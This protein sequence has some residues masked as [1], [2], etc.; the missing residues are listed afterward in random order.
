MPEIDETEGR[1]DDADLHALRA[2]VHEVDPIDPMWQIPPAGSWE[3]IA[4]E[5]GVAAAASDAAPDPVE[6]P[7][8]DAELDRGLDLE[9]RPHLPPV[10]GAPSTD[11]APGAGAVQ[12]NGVP[13]VLLLAVAVVVLFV[14]VAVVS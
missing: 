13:P 10:P 2:L 5:A 12:P 9:P 14:I 8:A 6:R 1:G 11:R 4:E 3:R 7:L